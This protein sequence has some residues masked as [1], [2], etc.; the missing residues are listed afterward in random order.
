MFE[1][2]KMYK[3]FRKE[4]EPKIQEKE[5]EKLRL[6]KKGKKKKNMKAIN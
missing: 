5:K 6:L 3:N 4:L 1:D 2:K